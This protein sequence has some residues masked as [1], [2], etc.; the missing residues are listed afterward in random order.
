MKLNANTTTFVC[1]VFKMKNDK[2][3]LAKSLFVKS[4]FTRKEIANTVGITEKTLR[5]WIE[6]YGW[7]D[8]KITESITRSHLLKEA[9]KQLKNIND[10]ID[11]ELGGVPNKEMSDAKAVIRK[12]IEALSEQPLYI[13]VE[14]AEE[15][16][17]WLSMNHPKEL[18]QVTSL[19]YEFIEE[20]AKKQG[21]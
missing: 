19:I 6:E 13:Y 8:L 21:L 15:F 12:E 2:K 17:S 1:K 4:G 9:Y 7:E 16:T 5:K 11:R 14:V 10:Y 18:K 3:E 20:L